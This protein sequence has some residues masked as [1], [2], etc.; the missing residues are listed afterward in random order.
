MVSKWNLIFY[1]RIYTIY[2]CLIYCPPP[3]GSIGLGTLLTVT[4]TGFISEKASIFVGK[5]KCQVEQITG[6]WKEFNKETWCS[7]WSFAHNVVQ[8]F[9]SDFFQMCSR[10]HSGVQ[11]G[12]CHCWYL[13]CHGQLSFFGLFTL[14]RRKDAQFHL[15]AHYYLF[16]SVFWKYSR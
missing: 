11:T 10:H 9:C 4:G 12:Q 16:L 1:W 7:N 5:A 6:K 2:C 3:P 13:P 14:R 8:R 15:P